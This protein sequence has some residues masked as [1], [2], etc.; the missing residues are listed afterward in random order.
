[1][2]QQSQNPQPVAEQQST[3]QPMSTYSAQA[4]ATP[5]NG[6][7]ITSMVLGIVAF[8]TGWLSIL[9]FA[10]SVPAV[11]FG[12]VALV[13]HQNKAMSIVGIC[14]AGV[15]ILFVIGVLMFAIANP[16]FRSQIDY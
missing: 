16:N 12:I 11:V 14:L 10:T 9:S 7:A 13:K 5:G 3:V 2:D 1:M 8:L 4:P 15:S 6:F